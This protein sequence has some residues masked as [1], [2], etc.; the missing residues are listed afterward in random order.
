MSDF[1]TPNK[2]ENNLPSAPGE[3]RRHLTSAERQA[4]YA[5]RAKKHRHTAK[6]SAKEKKILLGLI[7]AIAVFVLVVGLVA[8]LIVNKTVL[9]PRRQY[10]RA[11][12]LFAEGSY[13]KAYQAFSDLGSFRD[14]KERAAASLLKNAQVLS[15]RENVIMGYSS[16]QPWFS[17]DAEGGLRFDKDKYKGGTEL[18]IPDV[19]DDVLVTRIAAKGFFYADTF[20]KIEI[21]ASVTFIGERAFFACTALEEIV[22]SDNVTVIGESAFANCTAAKTLTI[23]KGLTEIGQRAFKDCASLTEVVIPEGVTVIASRAF[24]GCAELKK[25]SLPSTLTSIGGFA[26]T[27]CKKLE[28]VTFAGTRAALEAAA[29]ADDG[30]I[31]T[32]CKGLVCAG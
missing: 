2:D 17:F 5:E 6:K 13:L 9:E 1:P 14:S 31:I 3:P 19:F 10:E 16:T 15:G 4:I 27:D 21:P 32:G 26:F 28:S 8:G 24:N 11:E 20:T 7:A 30:E 22:L 25:L 23:G 18:V 29:K 12:A